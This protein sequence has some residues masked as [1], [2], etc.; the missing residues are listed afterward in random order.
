[1]GSLHRDFANPKL[2]PAKKQIDTKKENKIFYSLF[3]AEVLKINDFSKLSH[4]NN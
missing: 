1:M 2:P 4:K 3:T